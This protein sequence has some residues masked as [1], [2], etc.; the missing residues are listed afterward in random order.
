MTTF[1]GNDGVVKNS[2]NAVAEVRSFTVNQA[3]ETV[4]D[5]VMGD[6]WR[7]HKLT[8]KTWSG[9]VECFWDD[10]DSTGQEAWTVGSS[11]TLTLLP[12]GTTTGDYSLSGTATI[13]GVNHSQNSDGIVERSFDFQGNG[14]L[15]IST[16]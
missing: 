7:S 5:T 10:T 2:S 12:E 3:A 9:T 14:A 13:T 16:V 1:S 15:T 11:V 8:F 4:D 6:S